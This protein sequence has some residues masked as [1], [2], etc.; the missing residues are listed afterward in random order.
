[1]P[2]NRRKTYLAIIEIYLAQKTPWRDCQGCAFRLIRIKALRRYRQQDGFLMRCIL[3]PDSCKL[4]QQPL[5]DCYR[6]SLFTRIR[7]FP[8]QRLIIGRIG[9]RRLRLLDRWCAPALAA[10]RVADAAKRL[11]QRFADAANSGRTKQNN[12][13]R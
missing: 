11:A 2:S 5:V 6:L 9:L 7:G 4:L 1:M 12:R 13:D 10:Y 8:K 3:T